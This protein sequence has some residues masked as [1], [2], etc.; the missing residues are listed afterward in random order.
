MAC[1]G[2]ATEACGG[3]SRMGIFWNGQKPPPPPI[4]NLG[5]PGWTWLGC[6]TYATSCI[7]P[8]Q[9]LF[10]V[11]LDGLYADETLEKAIMAVE[12]SQLKCRYQEAAPI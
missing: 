10:L 4:N 1:S 8:L 3:S 7:I 12:L 6:Y 11:T 2:N 5:P 9:L